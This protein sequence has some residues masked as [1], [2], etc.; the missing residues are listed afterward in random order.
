MRIDWAFIARHVDT[1]Q[2]G[3]YIASGIGSNV[4]AVAETPS[5]LMAPCLM[6]VSAPYDE[7]GIEKPLVVR[8]IGT[9]PMEPVEPMTLPIG[10]TP[11]PNTP[12]G[13]QITA[14]S[15]LGVSFVAAERGTYSIEMA[16]DGSEYSL[17]VIVQ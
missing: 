7:A 11:G 13:W 6:Q 9:D 3:T 2:D 5:P 15:P 8:V 17:P 16:L 10:I 12:E 14:I 1:L 4:F